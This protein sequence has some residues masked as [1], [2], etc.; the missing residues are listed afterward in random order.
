MKAYY[1]EALK[2]PENKIHI[3]DQH[4]N[5]FTLICSNGHNCELRLRGM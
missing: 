4:G 1:D 5:E 2:S 3:N